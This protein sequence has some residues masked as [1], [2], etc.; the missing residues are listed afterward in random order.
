[1]DIDTPE[2]AK[3]FIKKQKRA[4]L[5]AFLI[6]AVKDGLTIYG[7]GISQKPLPQLKI[8]ACAV[9]DTLFEKIETGEIQEEKKKEVSNLVLDSDKVIVNPASGY[10]RYKGQS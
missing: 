10:F 2:Q 7:T 8:M 9:I 3:K 5:T 6:Q 1:M 4:Y